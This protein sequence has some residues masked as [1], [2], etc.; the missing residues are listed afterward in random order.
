MEKGEMMRSVVPVEHRNEEARRSR[1]HGFAFVFVLFSLV[2][3]L[4]GCQHP[5]ETVAETDRRH[6][7]ILRV[8][9]G[10]MLRDIDDVLML[11]EP[12]HLTDRRVP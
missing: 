9:E 4:Y 7:R 3:S 10:N 8:N 6:N 2:W 12:S 5:G 11:E 1:L